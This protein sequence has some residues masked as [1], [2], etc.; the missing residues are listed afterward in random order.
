M[1]RDEKEVTNKIMGEDECMACSELTKEQEKIVGA[2]YELADVIRCE[3][4][5]V[6]RESLVS[7]N[8]HTIE[9]MLRN[10]II[11]LEVAQVIED[12]CDTLVM[13]FAA[14]NTLIDM[15]DQEYEED[16]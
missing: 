4:K 1:R 14:D 7:F 8:P 15:V 13:A 6:T 10:A 11:E 9:A 16:I 3:S 2:L 12:A 5:E